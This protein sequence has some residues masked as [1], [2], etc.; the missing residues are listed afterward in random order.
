MVVGCLAT[1]SSS[2]SIPTGTVV[3]VCR[4]F[5]LAHASFLR[6]LRYG[7]RI[8]A[9]QLQNVVTL[10]HLLG[11]SLEIIVIH[12]PEEERDWDGKARNAAVVLLTLMVHRNGWGE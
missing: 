8:E 5:E 7:R 2:T 9:L 12:D 11:F 1:G 6:L 3:D 4:S 10:R